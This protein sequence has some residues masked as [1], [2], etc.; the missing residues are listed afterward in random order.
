MNRWFDH[1]DHLG[2]LTT[3]ELDIHRLDWQNRLRSKKTDMFKFLPHSDFGGSIESNRTVA[4]VIYF[5][6]NYLVGSSQV[7]YVET[8]N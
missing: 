6:F 5:S 3:P 4:K 1:Q 2:S 8:F 7:L